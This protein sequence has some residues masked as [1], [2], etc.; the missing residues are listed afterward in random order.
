MKK[1]NG[2]PNGNYCSIILENSE[3]GVCPYWNK[4]NNK[5]CCSYVGLTVKHQENK[6]LWNQVK[7]C[8]VNEP[9]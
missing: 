5:V 2:V 7:I 3:L 9:T 6:L 1:L 4:N 8:G